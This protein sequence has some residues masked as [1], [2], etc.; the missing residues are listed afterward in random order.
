MATVLLGTTEF[1]LRFPP[2]GFFAFAVVA[3]AILAHRIYGRYFE[4]MAAALMVA[5]SFAALSYARSVKSYTAD[6]CFAALIPVAA[7]AVAGSPTRG[8]WIA[9]GILLSVAPLFSFPSMLVGA[10]CAIFLLVVLARKLPCRQWLPSWSTS[11]LVAGCAVAAY[12]ITFLRSQ[13]SDGLTS[14]FGDGLPPSASGRMSDV[15]WNF[16]RSKAE[17]RALLRIDSSP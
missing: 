15:P 17:Y 1:A 7:L 16:G 3:T 10:S 12:A 14:Y 2:L 8:R 9:Y 11:H 5:T 13:R 4:T 6:L